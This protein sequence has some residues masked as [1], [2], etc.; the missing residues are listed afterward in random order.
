MD[1]NDTSH[2]SFPFFFLHTEFYKEKTLSEP[3]LTRANGMYNNVANL[4]RARQ[5]KI[6]K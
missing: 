4:A 1:S 2:N 6:N 5:Q 3:P